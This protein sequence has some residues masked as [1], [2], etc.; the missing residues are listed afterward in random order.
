MIEPEDKNFSELDVDIIEREASLAKEHIYET[1][2]TVTTTRNNSSQTEA[3]VGLSGNFTEVG[4]FIKVFKDISCQTETASPEDNCRR[5]KKRNSDSQEE[6]M[7]TIGKTKESRLSSDSSISTQD[8]ADSAD[9]GHFSTKN[10]EK[11]PRSPGSPYLWQPEGL[12][13]DEVS[14][15][16]KGWPFY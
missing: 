13:Q 4:Q 1:I 9:S 8:S 16:V 12:N 11:S 10:P 2:D 6:D 3:L 14:M 5:N 15:E 7:A